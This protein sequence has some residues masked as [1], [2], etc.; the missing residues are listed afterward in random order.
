MT[1]IPLVR[2]KVSSLRTNGL[3]RPPAV[4]DRPNKQINKT[5]PWLSTVA[6]VVSGMFSA[7]FT[8]SLPTTANPTYVKYRGKAGVRSS[9]A[10]V[11][12][13]H[14]GFGGE[15]GR[16]RGRGLCLLYSIASTVAPKAKTSVH[17]WFEIAVRRL[18]RSPFRACRSQ[19]QEIPARP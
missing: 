17:V 16:Y 2:S 4:T 7:C 13:S 18:L 8:V 6:Q 9:G 11:V 1:I 12:A 3:I 15:I 19:T 14:T 10:G 5:I